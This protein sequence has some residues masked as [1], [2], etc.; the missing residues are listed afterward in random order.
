MVR[1]IGIIPL[2]KLPEAIFLFEKFR[3]VE[4]PGSSQG[5]ILGSSVGNG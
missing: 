1:R 3:G 2:R 5:S 4:Q